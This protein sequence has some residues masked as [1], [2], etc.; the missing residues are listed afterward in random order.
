MQAIAILSGTGTP[1]LTDTDTAMVGSILAE[2]DCDPAPAEWLSAGEAVQFPL[3]LKTPAQ[4]DQI[5]ARLRPLAAKIQSDFNI[6]TAKGR[7]KALLIADMDST[8]ITSESLDDL[9]EL[10]GKGQAVRAITNRSMAGELDFE[11]ALRQRLQMLAGTP[12]SLLKQLTDSVTFSPGAEA[13]IATMAGHGAHCVLASGGFTFM[14]EVVAARLG[15]HEHHA[16][17]LGISNAMLDGTIKGKVLDQ[18]AKQIQLLASAAQ[19]GISVDNAIAVGDGANDRDMISL[20]GMGVAWR[21]KPVLKQKTRLWL[22]H[23]SL[24]GLLWLQGYHAEEI[25]RP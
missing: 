24:K 1:P 12:Q 16:N 4:Q 17:I 11:Q 18:N 20:A 8:I 9:A 22:D 2:L 15:F 19:C 10:A 21:G 13:L 3:L 7:R 14:T 5:I 25:I 23:S 6:V